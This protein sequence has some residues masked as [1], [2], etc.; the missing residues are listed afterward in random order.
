MHKTEPEPKLYEYSTHNRHPF[1]PVP[2]GAND[3][4]VIERL[5][6]FPPDI[7]FNTGDLTSDSTLS[8][9]RE[10]SGF[11]AKL[12]CEN[13]LSIPGNHDKFSK[14]SHEYFREYIY[15]GSFIQPKDPSLTKKTKVFI[16]PS[17]ARL[18]DYFTEMN[19]TRLFN[20]DGETVLIICNETNLFQED[21]GVME[22]QVLDSLREQIFSLKFDRAL[23]L[24]HHSI[25]TTDEDPLANSKRVTDFVLDMGI[26]ANFCGH[27]HELD[28][29]EIS[30]LVRGKKFRQFMC[31]ALSSVNISRDK[32]MFCT[33]EN[34][35]TPDE[36]I[37]IT[38]II[39][40]ETGIEFLETELKK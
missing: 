26:E 25:L 28:I 39:S 38:R 18:N 30:G 4:R 19:Y 31:G 10:C 15:G 12:K 3:E 14:R 35:G 8:E 5:N 7:V 17:S 40:T 27:T 1:R 20:F 6:A 16:N 33:Y 13:I 21:R 34:F 22:I 32:N 2:L 24:S 11:L 9:F 36:I 37:K 29:V 23:M